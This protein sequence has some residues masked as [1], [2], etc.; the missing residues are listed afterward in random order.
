VAD[1]VA[2]RGTASHSKWY[3]IAQQVVLHRTARGIASHSKRYCIA[4]VFRSHVGIRC[5][6]RLARFNVSVTGGI[7]K[8]AASPW[9][10]RISGEKLQA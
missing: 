1:I 9:K 5:N 10:N 7:V 6:Q 8:R 4:L 2:A 3:C